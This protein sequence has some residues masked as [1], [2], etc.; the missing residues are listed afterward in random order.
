LHLFLTQT[1]TIKDDVQL[2]KRGKESGIKRRWIKEREGEGQVR[3]E[4]ENVCLG[5]CDRERVRMNVS[6][7]VCVCARECMC[8][9]V[10]S[11]CMCVPVS[12]FKRECVCVCERERESVCVKE[13]KREGEIENWEERG[14]FI[15]ELHG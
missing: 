14:R 11:E 7:S 8:V 2:E 12:M 5:V 4:I 1:S 13:R 10:S 9:P 3:K 15:Q 6:A